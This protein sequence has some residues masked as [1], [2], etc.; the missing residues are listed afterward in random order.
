MVLLLIGLVA[1]SPFAYLGN[2]PSATAGNTTQPELAEVERIAPPAAQKFSTD[3]PKAEPTG[4]RMTIDW[5]RQQEGGPPPGDP[6]FNPNVRVWGDANEETRPSMAQYPAIGSAI[7]GAWFLVFQ[8]FNGADWDVYMSTTPDNSTPWQTE[9]FAATNADETNPCIAITSVGT[10]IVTWQDASQPA[11]FVF[12]HSPNGQAFSG[13]T[14]DVGSM[15]SGTMTDIQFP[16]VVV[17][18]NVGAYPD[19]IMFQAQAWCT[20]VTDCEGGAHTAFWIGE[21]F[22]NDISGWTFGLGGYRWNV[23]ATP[24][25]TGGIPDPLHPSAWWGSHDYTMAMDMEDVDGAE[26]ILLWIFMSEDASSITNGWQY[27]VASDDGIFTAGASD[28][29]KAVL[30]GSIRSASDP[31]RHQIVTFSTTTGWSNTPGG[32]WIDTA[33]T[34]QRSASVAGVGTT[35]H[36]TYY[37][38]TVMTEF[39][40][41]SAGNS[42]TGPEKVSDNAGTAF[43]DERATSVYIGENDMGI[44]WQDSRDGDKNI[45]VTLGA[46]SQLGNDTTGPI[47]RNAMT[48]PNPY[49]F[50]ISNSLE[51]KATIDDS[52]TGSRYIVDA[53]LQMTDTTVSNPSLVDWS[54]AWAMN[55]TGVNRSRTETAWLW[56]NDTAAG[57]SVGSCHRFW[58][59]GQDSLGNWGT[60]GRVDV[61]AV[62]EVPPRAPVMTGAELTG[63]G[64][65]D[66]M[67]HWNA[68][69]DDGGGNYNVIAYKVYRSSA[70]QG[71]FAQIAIIQATGKQ[72]YSYID[73]GA[74]HRSFSIFFYCVVASSY[75]YDSP[76]SNIAAKFYRSM[77]TGKQLVS[78]PLLQ[79]NDDP[80]VVFQ[81]LIY[82]YVRTYI[83]GTP[84]PWWCHKPGLFINSLDHVSVEQGFWIDLNGPGTMTVAGLVPQDVVIG[85]K[86]GWNMIGFPSFDESYTFADLDAAIGGSLQLVEMYDANAGP[87]YLQKVLRNDWATTHLTVGYAYMIRVSNDVDWSVPTI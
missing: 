58:I 54:H 53:E 68:S 65:T 24:A 67:L 17:Q 46:S 35:F 27:N 77:T 22:A 52:R 80:A 1:T 19:G 49:L 16:T 29:M 83:A 74:G 72:S 64:F 55:L 71:P 62:N 3:S 48:I 7:D 6:P 45:Y 8:H 87:Y 26:W 5:T 61:C 79:A 13:Y 66:V 78:F 44:A 86:S 34:D 32:E 40:T 81:T 18:R 38:G 70:L 37:S 42:W 60:G 20:S 47:T 15:W 76:C 30:A 85:L 28:G 56:A 25:G 43:C 21:P 31:T 41:T 84:N 12:A 75:M 9:A 69:A 11:L 59:R 50:G 36:V 10:V 4:A 63:A 33:V 14:L 23:C 82:T 2:A 57:W 51:V 39:M 73:L